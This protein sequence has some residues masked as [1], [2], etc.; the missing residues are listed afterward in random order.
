MRRALVES[1]PYR[2]LRDALLGAHGTN[3]WM[4]REDL[5][6]RWVR[7]DGIEI[8]P[9]GRPLA[10]PSRAR[11]RYVDRA[12]RAT[13]LRE[14]IVPDPSAMPAIDVV[15]DAQNL[16]GFADASLDFLIAAHVLEHLQDPVGALE[17]FA[18][19]L[20]PGGIALI[21]LPDARFSFDAPRERTTIEHVLRDHGEG[22]QVSRAHHYEE[23][24]TVIEGREGDDVAARVAEYAS[25][26]AHHHFHVWELAD[27]LA[28]MYALPIPFE[29]VE[30]RACGEEFSVVLRR[31]A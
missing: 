27:F 16:A 15:A 8:G 28:L 2:R 26:D 19:V 21:T 12:D 14:E 17:R 30:A 3:M 22:P 6:R 5:A 9:L 25:T 10:L 29:L 13:L 7:G 20:R 24:A 11:V 4:A 18:A 31:T 1:L 23:W